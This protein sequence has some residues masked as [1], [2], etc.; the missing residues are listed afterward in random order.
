M[1]IIEGYR[2]R[3]R[4]SCL[5]TGILA[6]LAL[7]L[8]AVMMIYGNTI[9][10]PGEI[11]A[12]L[13]GRET[14]G[15][16]FTIKTLRLPRML[17][18]ILCGFA[19]GAAG[20]T[21]QKLLRNPLASPDIIG[22]TSG[23][24]AA[25]VF[26][27]LVLHL[28]GNL[29]SMLAVVSGLAV[30]LLIYFLSQGEGFSNGRLILTGIGMQAFLRAMISWILLKASEYDVSSALRWLSGSLNNVS[31]DQIPRLAVVVLLS[32]AAIAAL[33]RSLETMQLGDDYASVLG[34]KLNLVRLALILF[35]LL[36]IAFA[37]SVSGPIAS[38]AFLAGPI[39]SRLSGNGNSNVLASG[40]T[41]CVLVLASDLIGQYALPVR[42]PVGVITGIL[43][44]P[45]LIWLL[46]RL[47]RES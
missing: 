8:A 38:V 31:I 23:A 40:F 29:V 34:V 14:G 17:A 11:L 2:E 5:V 46:I 32:M 26:G 30:S 24:S 39:S 13:T 18:A 47:N 45:Y 35:A 27:I 25:A 3:R 37:T 1:S 16:V 42:Y 4:R 22:V 21:F 44:A 28:P 20:N 12:V 43:G 15:A 10:S 36:L 41:G 6:C 7:G 19:F 9:Y 33:N